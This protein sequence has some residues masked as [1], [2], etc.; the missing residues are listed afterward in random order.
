M[1][2]QHTLRYILLCL[3]LAAGALPATAA[4]SKGTVLITGANRGI[5]LALAER[6]ERGGYT[7]IGTARSPDTATE[8]RALDLRIEQLDVTSPDSV[9]AL[10]ER[11]KG[12]PIDILINNA[13]VGGEDSRDMAAL[14]IDDM[15]RVLD[16]NTLGP[17]RVI[18]A[19]YPN[20]EA[21]K[22]KLVANISSMMGSMT[23]NTWGC[24]AGYR[25]SKAALNSINKSFAVDY[26]KLGMTF[27]V[28][29][30]GYVQT[31]MN[32][33]KGNITPEH[34]AKGLFNVITR[35][36]PVDN[37]KFYDF[38]GDELPW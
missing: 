36:K 38:K 34:S 10:A 9:K 4:D 7:V 17:V 14:D 25:A 31:D 18:Q 5:G 33:G 26:G 3:A 20:L 13:G 2:L 37:G 22:T 19:L 35:L 29:H 23:M 30:P 8:L 21:G 28:L 16:V 24:C 12:T 27:V 11:L 6:F 1:S 15:S 32:E